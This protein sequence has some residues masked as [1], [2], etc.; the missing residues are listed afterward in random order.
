MGVVKTSL[1]GNDYIGAFAT[2]TERFILL[3][4]NVTEHKEELLS[5]TLSVQPIKTSIDG[6]DL[7]GIYTAGNSNGIILPELMHEEE[8]HRLKAAMPGFNV[9]RMHTDLNALGN[10]ILVN[11][12]IAIINPE[13][14]DKEEKVIRDVLGVEVVRAAFGGFTTVGASNILT[15]AGAVLN[16]RTTDE[17]LEDA[18]KWLG[19]DTT[20]STAN[21]GSLSIGLCALANSKGMVVGEATTGFELAR[22]S[23]GL[24]L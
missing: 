14:S 11:D 21:T 18:K 24:G 22:L 7:L 4:L 6:S 8:F 12:K 16:N 13:Y 10:N 3:G 9:H 20:Q 19:I 23:Q 5:K 15:N 17:E 2:V 1:N